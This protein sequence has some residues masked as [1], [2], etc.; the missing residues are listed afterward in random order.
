MQKS[1][2]T[3]VTTVSYLLGLDEEKLLTYYNLSE[4]E[5]LKANENATIVRSLCR[6]RTQLF[7]NFAKICIHSLL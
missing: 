4:I 5:K 3:L 1:T 2:K 6:I 7:K